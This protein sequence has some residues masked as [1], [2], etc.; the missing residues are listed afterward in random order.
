MIF[1]LFFRFIT[2]SDPFF[3]RVQ[4][5]AKSEFEFSLLKYNKEIQDLIHQQSCENIDRMILTFNT[6]P[7]RICERIF[8]FQLFQGTCQFLDL[9]SNFALHKSFHWSEFEDL[10]N[11]PHTT[12]GELLQLCLMFHLKEKNKC[13]NKLLCRCWCWCFGRYLQCQIQGETFPSWCQL[14]EWILWNLMPQRLHVLKTF[15]EWCEKLSVHNKNQPNNNNNNN[16]GTTKFENKKVNERTL[17]K[18]SSLSQRGS[19]RVLARSRIARFTSSES[20]RSKNQSF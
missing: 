1:L 16:K 8:I 3:L 6:T 18:T 12:Y 4:R 2:F 10:V 17:S 14:W 9:L 11:L 13:H 20:E 7:R 15:V 5:T 19:L